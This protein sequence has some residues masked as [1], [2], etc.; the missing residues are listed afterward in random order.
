MREQDFKVICKGHYIYYKVFEDNSGALEHAR[1]P[2]LRP[3]IKTGFHP[4]WDKKYQ[5][6]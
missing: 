2:K 6:P 1:L 5:K 3:R 4:V